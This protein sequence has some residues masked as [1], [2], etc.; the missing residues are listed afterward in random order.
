ME[1]ASLDVRNDQAQFIETQKFF[2]SVI[3]A[4][5]GVPPHKV[6]D[7]DRATFNNVEQQDTDFTIDAVLPVARSFETAI[8]RDLLT[9]S[10]RAA[11]I[12]VKFNLDAVE[13]ANLKDR[14]EALK[15]MRENGVINADEW[16]QREDMNPLPEGAGGQDYIRPMNMQTAEQA[17]AALENQNGANEPTPRNQEDGSEEG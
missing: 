8:E 6:G 2:R 9:D 5:F 12:I 10:D 16:R 3:A 13:R 4:P 11:D 15:V 14:A 17:E 7:L 1:L